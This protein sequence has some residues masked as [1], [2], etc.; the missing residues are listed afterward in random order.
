LYKHILV[1]V[2]ESDLAVDTVAKAVELAQGLGAQLTFVH[3]QADYGATDEGALVRVLSPA[4]YSEHSSGNA[5]GVLARA[6]AEADRVGL[7]SGIVARTSDQ[8]YEVIIDVAGERGCDLIF[9][10]S[11]GR[12][13]LKGLMLGS[14]TQKVLAHTTIPVLISSV[15]SNAPTPEIDAAINTIKG[16]HRS[17]GAVIGGLRHVL[18][19]ALDKDE[20][21]N[22]PL[23][24]AMLFY[25]KQFPDRLHHPREEHYLFTRL[26]ARAPALGD[27]LDQLEVQHKE[28]SRLIEALE[29]ALNRYETAP[30]RARL[31]EVAAIANRF[32]TE[33]WAHMNME[34]RCVLPECVA[35]LSREDWKQIETVFSQHGDPRFDRDSEAD[36]DKLLSRIMSVAR[37]DGVAG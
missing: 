37:S 21:V 8:P 27:L 36:F 11:H 33:L 9:M 25:F 5:M 10:A 23:V 4:E 12:R 1:P 26:R 30:D 2:D 20:A 16:E 15:A 6:Q 22:V 19:C 17:M 34:E 14:Q 29:G 18:R 35:H 31:E 13:G 7:E 3:A 28:Q 32:T 24:K